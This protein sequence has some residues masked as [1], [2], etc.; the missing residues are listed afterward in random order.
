ME[1]ASWLNPLVLRI[2]LARPDGFFGWLAVKIR[3]FLGPLGFA[4]W[5]GVVIWGAS[6]VA[7]NWGS[8]V[9]DFN[10]VIWQYNGA[11]LLAVWLVIK[12]LHEISHGVFCRHFGAGVREIG[13]IWILF[14]P[15]SYVDATPSLASGSKWRRTMVALAGIYMDLFVAA[16]AAVV[17][18]SSDAGS[19][20][21]SLIRR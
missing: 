15:I 9:R 12:I 8:F 13:V 6:A 5:L 11:L 21:R 18:S 4:I 14:F 16:C 7:L 1:S 2:P 20:G 19:Y 17:W 3:I 10:G